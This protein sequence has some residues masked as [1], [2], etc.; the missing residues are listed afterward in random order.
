MGVFLN[1]RKLA[2]ALVLALLLLLCSTPAYSGWTPD[3]GGEGGTKASRSVVLLEE[4]P[5][6]GQV[7]LAEAD[8]HGLFARYTMYQRRIRDTLNGELTRQGVSVK[9]LEDDP[10]FNRYAAGDPVRVG[11]GFVDGT[12]AATP[13]FEDVVRKHMPDTIALYYRIDWMTYD[14]SRRI[15]EA[16]VTLMLRHLRKLNVRVLGT[17]SVAVSIQNDRTLG[18]D[19]ACALERAVRAGVR[20]GDVREQVARIGK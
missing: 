5:D 17:K 15:A 3:R 16:N 8:A 19:M 11:V 9:L 6:A 10:A 14:A 7:Q 4:A 18:A 20:A 2:V 1:G 13:R 12:L